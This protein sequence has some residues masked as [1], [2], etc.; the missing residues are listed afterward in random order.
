MSRPTAPTGLS[1]QEAARRLAQHGPNALE[2]RE[3]RG[4]GRTVLAVATEPMFALLL[5]AAGIYLVLGDLA[6][7]LLL[8]FFAVM[9]VALVV[10]QERRSERA[11]DALRELAAPQVRV[12]RDGEVRRIP[13]RELV[14]GDLFLVGEGERVAAD[15]VLREC[16]GLSV[17]ESLLTGES[18]PVRKRPQ[19]EGGPPA[20]EPGGDD[21]PLVYASTLAVGGN[22][23]AEVTATGA[24]TRVG[25]IGASLAAIELAA[26]P[27]QRH[28]QR[29]VRWLAAGGLGLSLLLVLWWGLR[30]GEWLQGLLAGIALAMAMLPEEFPMALAVFLAL[31]AWR[32]ARVKV[33]ARRPAVIEALGAC[34]VLCV[35]K[36]GTL[37]ENRMRV[38]RLVADE[39]DVDLAGAAAGDLP[40][41]VRRLLEVAMLASRRG[42]VEPMDNAIL[43]HGDE[44]LAGTGHLH[45]EWLL[46]QEYPLTPQL[47]A[48]SQ[49]W[50]GEDGTARIAA[51]GAP[52]AV[53]DLCHLEPEQ[54]AALQARVQALADQGLRVLA[55]AEGD[56]SGPLA[57]N[58]HDYDFSLL[59]LVAFE[60]PLRAS[61]PGAVAQARRAG[62][63][64]AMITGDH[65]ATALAIARQAGLDTAAG[66]LTG[67]QLREM[68]DGRL[69]QAV[70]EVRVFAR[71]APA[72]KLRLVQ[73]LA[74]SGETVAMTGDGVNDAPALKAAHIGIA[75]GVRGTDVAREAAGIVLLE[76][77]F[78]HIVDGVRVGRRI[79]DNL[80][81]VMTYIMAI[82]V[83]IAGLAL[84]PVLLGAPPMMLPVHVVVTEMIID[85]VCSLAFEK[86][87]AERGVMDR[88]PR[89]A[90]EP[91]V[92]GSLLV[93]ALLQGGS[94]LAASLGVYL[95]GLH[96]GLPT[97]EART[98][99]FIGLT[100]G[101][102]LLVW[103]NASAGVGM[104]ALLGRDFA[105]FWGVAAV[106]TG[107]LALAVTVPGVRGLL[108]FGAPP[109]S[110]LGLALAAVLGTVMLA[111]LVRPRR[112]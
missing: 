71:V 3:H 37:T 30:E 54:A 39:A 67:A 91:L 56:A 73:A 110:Q 46:A 90:G 44:A 17:D 62:I 68:D 97:D 86:T 23:V 66:A 63:A 11:L 69:A 18:V 77:D 98:L 19:P 49:V 13:A 10:G 26:T 87:P 105:V 1:S 60:D 74:A 102:L 48:M 101:N 79:Y 47:L 4:L 43:A 72:D 107:L 7:G 78:G 65:A 70:R 20:A 104:R 88:P 64:V 75:M 51:K 89:P 40:P 34:T 31:G 14:P 85:P 84:L 35:D 32:L 103:L 36:T 25:Q 15:A 57:D 100:A 111:W 80:R 96:V 99:A 109:A 55:V 12:L 83:P 24:A 9:T 38:R 16:A 53:A 76:E 8:S 106:A 58:P 95:Y 27:L 33:L 6:E 93:Q 92:G 28:L 82:H 52:E 22:G 112:A 59:G 2:S 108:K 50:T 45:P 21:L 61:V 94:L 81:K 5:A 41:P 42:G 29:L